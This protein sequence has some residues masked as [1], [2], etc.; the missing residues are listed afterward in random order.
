MQLQLKT[1][2]FPAKK[3]AKTPLRP[4]GAPHPPQIGSAIQLT[5]LALLM[6]GRA[7]HQPTLRFPLCGFWC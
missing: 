6:G 7:S 1:F 4:A 3:E 5:L 2:F